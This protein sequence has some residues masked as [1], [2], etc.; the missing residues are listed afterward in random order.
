MV[1]RSVIKPSAYFDSVTLMLVQRDVRQ[2]PGI[3]EAGAVMGTDANKELLRDAGLLTPEAEAA[4][5]DDL[6]LAVR[7]TSDEA[8]VAAVT[9]AET[10]LTQRRETAATGT[11]RPKTVGTAV[12]TLAGANLAL[13]SVPGRFAAGVAKEALAAGL[14]V[15]LFSDNVPLD[16]EIELKQTAVARGLL[17]MGPDCGTAIIGGTGLGFANHV[18]RGT[19]GIVGAAGTGIQEVASLVHRGGAGVSHAI[20][21]GGRELSQAVGGPTAAAGTSA[22]ARRAGLFEHAARSRVRAGVRDPQPRSHRDRHG[23]RRVHG[24]PVTSH[25]GPHTAPSAPVAGSRR[26]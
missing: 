8:A 2:L 10:L 9:A 22:P 17:L 3:E 16:A 7:A 1:I 15:M 4:R 18:R 20:G 6:I 25:A 24:G 21:T 5:P 13:I 26:S 23:E 11:Y 12:R 14:H 19:I